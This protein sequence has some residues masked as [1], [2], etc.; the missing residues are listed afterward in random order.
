MTV[1]RFRPDRRGSSS[2]WP[3]AGSSRGSRPRSRRS[4]QALTDYRFD[5]AAAALYE[6]TWYEFCDWYLELTKPVLQGEGTT[7]AQKRGTRRTLVT[8]LRGLA[9]CAASAGAVHHR[10]DLAARE[11]ADCA[12]RRP[13]PIVARPRQRPTA[14]CWRVIRPATDFAADAEAEAEVAWMQAGHPRG[15]PDP[16]R[17][18]YRALAQDSA[19]AAERRRARCG[20]GRKTRRLAHASRGPRKRARSSRPE[21]ARRNPP[22]PLSA[23]SRC[24]CRWRD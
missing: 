1:E 4:N 21:R 12:A 13:P 11:S 18:G 14:S 3:I 20:A 23:S 7:E 24:W 16:R 19:A 15:A 2:R 22:R 5:F 8:T 17:D 10:G 9:A 6:F